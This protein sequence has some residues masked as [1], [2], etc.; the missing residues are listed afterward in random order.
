MRKRLQACLV[1][2]LRNNVT[3]IHFTLREGAVSVEMRINDRMKRLRAS[4]KDTALFHYLMYRADLDVSD[5]L[6]P[7]TGRFE[8]TADGKVLSLRF[9][10]MT[11]YHMTSGVLRIL[12]QMPQLKTGDLTCSA[13]HV[14]WLKGITGHRSGLY[15]FSGPTGSGKTTTLYTL[16]NETEGRKIYTLED[17][18]EV[19]SGNYVQLQVNGRGHLSW[20]E[21]IRQLMRHDPDI[22][23]IGEVRDRI[24]AENAVRCA[25]SGHLVLTSLHAG[26]TVTAIHRLLDLGVSE[27]QL[28]DVLS[29]IASQRL[30][31]PEPGRRLC[32]FEIMDRKEI[33]YYHEHGKHSEHFV[34]L[35]ENIAQAVRGGIITEREAERDLM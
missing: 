1:T 4:E 26:S 32:I 30:F 7:Q 27:T 5:V 19:V 10:V 16:L 14:R 12:N 11:S 18:V 23:M 34:T 3:D 21:G 9:A 13:A 22:I 17:P 29:G 25:L 15:V 2:A 24:A 31:E 20:E 28:Y 6:T 33:G 35:Q 8:E